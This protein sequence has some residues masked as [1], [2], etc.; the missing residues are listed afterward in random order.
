MYTLEDDQASSS[1]L[2]KRDFADAQSWS[3]RQG[4]HAPTALAASDNTG[5]PSAQRPSL[6]MQVTDSFKKLKNLTTPTQTTTGGQG[7]ALAALTIACI[8]VFFTALDQTVVVT[9]LPQIITDLQIPIIQLDHASWIISAYLLGFIIAMPLMGRVSDI[10]GRRRILLLCLIIFG[11]GSIFC[12]VAPILGQVWDLGF[13]NALHI[14]TSSPG[15]IWLIAARLLQAIGGGAVVAVAM[16]IAGDFY[17]QE[18]RALALG[19][20]GAVTEAG[21]ALGPLYGALI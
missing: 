15:L 1:H 18:R 16:A 12:G 6:Q 14:D 8:G 3:P 9:A 19:V 10:Y 5:T 2:R 20:I 21:G 4:D 17:G 7:I 11:L 13:L